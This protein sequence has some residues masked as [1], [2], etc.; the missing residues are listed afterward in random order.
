MQSWVRK[1]KITKE[2]GVLGMAT[3]GIAILHRVERT[4]GQ[5]F[6]EGKRVSHAVWA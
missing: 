2:T 3:V 4:L 6:E 1:S 5:S